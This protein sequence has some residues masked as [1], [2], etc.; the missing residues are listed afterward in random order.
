MLY[1]VI[2]TRKDNQYLARVKEWPEITAYDKRRDEAIRPVQ[3]QLLD[4]LTQQ[5]AEVVQIEVPLHC[6]ANDKQSAHWPPDFFEETAC[7]LANDPIE[8]APQSDYEI[9]DSLK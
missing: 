8:R 7:C 2:L 4:F 6:L 9:R 5:Q 3:S 1:D